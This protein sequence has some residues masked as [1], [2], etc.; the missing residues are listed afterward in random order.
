MLIIEKAVLS[1][2]ANFSL[3]TAPSAPDWNCVPLERYDGVNGS[4]LMTNI[5]E[6][7]PVRIRELIFI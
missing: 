5:P 7:V 6:V 4:P 1:L 2:R 3:V